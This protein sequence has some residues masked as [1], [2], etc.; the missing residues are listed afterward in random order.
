MYFYSNLET[1]VQQ[2]YSSACYELTPLFLEVW[3]VVITIYYVIMTLPRLAHCISLRLENC[4]RMC[5]VN[6]Q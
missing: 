5:Y 4:I 6:L 2:L 3:S 1:I